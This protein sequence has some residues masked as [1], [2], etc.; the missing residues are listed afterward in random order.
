MMKACPFCAEQIPQEARVCKFCHTA[1]LRKCPFC[2]E[3]IGAVEKSCPLCKSDLA[4]PVSRPKSQ[5]PLGEE[6]GIALTVILILLTCGIWG[7]YLQYK[8]GEELNRHEGKNRINPGVDL[9]LSI[10]TCGLWGIYLMYKYP[11]TLH[12]LTVE[13]GMPPVD[14]ALPCMLLMIFGFGIVSFA[15]LQ[16]EMNKHW[17]AHRTS[18]T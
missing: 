9:L 3:E 14:L 7:F 8:L 1:L 18:G 5:A 11:Q 10:V 4:A 13:E 17:E 16:N 12:D 6:R 2:A 15:I